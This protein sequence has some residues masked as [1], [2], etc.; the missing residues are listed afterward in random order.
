MA[1][2]PKLRVIRIADYSLLDNESKE[3]IQQMARQEL[4]KKG[5]KDVYLFCKEF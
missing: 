1:L 5:V 4:I 2:N 3:M